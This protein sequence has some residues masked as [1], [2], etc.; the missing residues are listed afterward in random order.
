VLFEPKSGRIIHIHG[1][2]TLRQD[3]KPTPQQIEAR[4]LRNAKI[5]G[6]SGAGLKAL[7]VPV[8]AVRQHG[9]LKV[10]QK[11]ENVIATVPRPSLK[12]LRGK[13]PSGAPKKR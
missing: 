8:S 11:G 5:F 6:H 10:D 3:R 1:T 9:V 7:H 2:T 12:E 13:D 4:A